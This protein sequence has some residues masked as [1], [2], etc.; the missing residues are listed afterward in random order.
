MIMKLNIMIKVGHS[1][2]KATARDDT[3]SIK[4]LSS[5]VAP[6]Q[7]LHTD[8]AEFYIGDILLGRTTLISEG[9][10]NLSLKLN[11]QIY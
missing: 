7:P 5:N 2:M 8:G 3:A 10:K 1:V 4:V 9:N 6:H 11:N